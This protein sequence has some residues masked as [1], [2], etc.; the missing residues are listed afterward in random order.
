MREKERL[1]SRRSIEAGT[2][3]E[4]TSH[5]VGP[6][7]S[8]VGLPAGSDVS[9]PAQAVRHPIGDPRAPRASFVCFRERMGV[10]KTLYYISQRDENHNAAVQ[11]REGV[12]H[13]GPSCRVASN[14]L[15]RLDLTGTV[16]APCGRRQHDGASAEHGFLV[17][18]AAY[19]GSLFLSS[20]STHRNLH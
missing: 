17:F 7:W 8:R 16:R 12:R 3:H 1:D 18:G 14:Y 9:L 6:A 4:P 2:A 19:G 11:R 5:R 20:P 10:T 15:G 13:G